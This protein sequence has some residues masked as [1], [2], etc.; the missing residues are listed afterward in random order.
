[1]SSKSLFLFLSILHSLFG[2]VSLSRRS[3]RDDDGDGDHD[4]DDD[5]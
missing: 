2:S 4:D 1:M 3:E 5:D